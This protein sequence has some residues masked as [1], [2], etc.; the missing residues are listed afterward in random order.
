[1]GTT[2]GSVLATGP[3][4]SPRR[5]CGAAG[6]ARAAG[7][8]P[9]AARRPR[10]RRLR[11]R[12]RAA[13]RDRPAHRA[14]GSRRHARRPAAAN[15]PPAC[16]ARR[17][18]TSRCK[19]G[20]SSSQT[21]DRDARAARQLGV[22]QR[23]EQLGLLA[24][25]RGGAQHV[26][27]R[28]RVHGVERLDEPV[29]HAGAGIELAVVARVLV[30][31]ELQLLTVGGRVLGASAPTMAAQAAPRWRTMPSSARRPGEAARR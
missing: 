1:M 9:C 2:R 14:R 23:V 4:P 22:H 28:R 24:Q 8:R 18:T 17:M 31:R 6:A 15:S 25:E 26:G 12:R 16:S 11:A 20:A 5:S 27:L 10:S 30:P 3:Y 29:T 7:S 13:P 21:L 19:A